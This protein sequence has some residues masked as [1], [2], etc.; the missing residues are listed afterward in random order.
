MPDSQLGRI[1]AGKY[2][3]DAVLGQGGMGVVYRAM[4]LDVDGEPMR[5]VALKMIRPDAKSAAQEPLVRRFRREARAAS[6]LRSPYVVTVH[7]SGETERGEL[8]YAME[9]VGGASLRDL[10]R[11]HGKLTPDQAVAVTRQ[12]CEALEEAHEQPQPIVHRDLKP[13]NVFVARWPERP[14]IKVADFG[15]AKVLGEESSGLTAP[16]SSLG[17]PLYMSPEQW[18]GAGVDARVSGVRATSPSFIS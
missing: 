2:R 8:Y 10:L 18:K 12:I 17:T 7:D 1:I 13:G 14:W 4:Q 9:F 16:G 15:I 11:E 3:L 5:A 6:R